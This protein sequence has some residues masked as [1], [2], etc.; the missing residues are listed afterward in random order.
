VRSLEPWAIFYDW[1]VHEA[2]NTLPSE[3]YVPYGSGRLMENYLYWQCRSARNESSGIRDP[4]LWVHTADVSSINIFGAEPKDSHSMADKLNAPVKPF[5]YLMIMILR[6]LLHLA[7]PVKKRE[8]FLFPKNALDRRMNF[9]NVLVL[10][11]SHQR[12]LVRALYLERSD[13][14]KVKEDA[15]ILVVNTGKGL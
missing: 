5:F 4:R 8:S 3:V 13:L 15:H 11:S 7:L 14:G 12:Q 6:L 2:F 9:Y 10:R 1:H